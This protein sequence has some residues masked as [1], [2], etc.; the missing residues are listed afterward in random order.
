[1]EHLAKVKERLNSLTELHDLVGA[2]RSMTATQAKEAQQAFSGTESYARVIEHAI[3]AAAQLAGPAGAEAFGAAGDG[4]PVLIEPLRLGAEAL[5]QA[6]NPA[7][8]AGARAL[9]TVALV[10]PGAEDALGPLR[11]V[12]GGE[13]V[14]A[15]ASAWDGRCVARFAAGD[16]LPLKRAVARALT[17]LRGGEDLPRVWQ[18]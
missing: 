1:M 5:G 9:A 6:A 17:A 7:G 8:L 14:V 2:L 13:G 4:R 3:A 18:I 16:A 11:A 12:L 10:A 15:A